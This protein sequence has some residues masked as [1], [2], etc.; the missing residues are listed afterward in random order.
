[1]VVRTKNGQRLLDWGPKCIP[2][3]NLSCLLGVGALLRCSCCERIPRAREGTS[4]RLTR[5]RSNGKEE[6]W[7]GWVRR[8]GVWFKRRTRDGSRGSRENKMRD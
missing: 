7:W 6:S 8:R 1:M 5:I 3:E 4:K 2:V